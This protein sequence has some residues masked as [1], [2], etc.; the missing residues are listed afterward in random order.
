MAVA[1]MVAAGLAG[2]A[3]TLFGRTAPLA[4]SVLGQPLPG[5]FLASPGPVWLIL[6]A[7]LV[8]VGGI[9][10]LI[11]RFTVTGIGILAGLVFITPVGLL[12]VIPAVLA[13][14]LVLPSLNAF[15]EFRP[16]WRGEGNPPPGPWR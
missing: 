16:R 14:L 2:L 9:G 13:L 8:I 5:W 3:V 1:V 4:E 6:Q 15:P 7:G 10:V 11:N 12:T